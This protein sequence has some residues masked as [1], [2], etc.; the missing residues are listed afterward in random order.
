MTR[1][2]C[3]PALGRVAL[4]SGLLAGIATRAQDQPQ[5][6]TPSGDRKSFETREAVDAHYREQLAELERRHLADLAAVAAR[7]EGQ[8]A[9]LTYRDLFNLAIARNLYVQAERAAERVLSD[10]LGSPDVRLLALFV[11]VVA[12]ADR[13]A[14][15]ESLGHLLAAIKER[16]A[17]AASGQGQRLER[18]TALTLGEAY[19][20][21]LIHAGRYD[22]ARQVCQLIEE[23]AADPAVKSHFAAR[24]ERLDM[25]GQPAPAIEGTGV[26]GERVRLEDHRGKVVLIYFWATWCPP[27]D[28]EMVR[29]A[30][31]YDRYRDKGFVVL[32]VNLDAAR[33]GA[34]PSQQVKAAVRRFLIAHQVGFPNVLGGAGEQDVARAYGVTDIPVNFLVDRDGKI[35]HFE[36]DEANRE[37]VV[38]GA[39]GGEGASR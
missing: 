14:F 31:L 6:P 36:L 19:F 9:D 24:R 28:L 10:E 37:R 15:D 2:R 1:I 29:L 20:Q 18:N 22:V 12:E 39:V 33:E 8:D 16:E 13:G 17:A 5:A 3:A 25:L 38:A 32:G 35:I 7:Q 11:N 4:I 30:A 26:D 34:G 23:R 27:C 21:R